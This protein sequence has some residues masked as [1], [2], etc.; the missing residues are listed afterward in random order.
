MD[1]NQ[2]L[3]DRFEEHRG[4]LRAVAYRMLGSLAEADD[5]VQDT[6]LR[7][8]GAGVGEV[9]NLRGWLT[10][11]T[12]RVCLNMLRSR[13]LR[14][15]EALSVHVP[16]PVL[17][18]GRRASA[19][20]GGAAGR[21]GR[22]RPAGGPG[23]PGPG[24]TAGVRPARHVRAAVRGDRPDGEQ[25]PGAHR[26]V[27][28]PAG[29]P[30]AP[31]PGERGSRDGRHGT[32][33]APQRHGLHDRRRPDRRDRTRSAT[34]SAS[35]RSPQASSPE[36]TWICDKRRYETTMSRRAQ[37]GIPGG[38]VFC[39]RSV[40]RARL[41]Q[42]CHANEV[43]Q[44][45]LVSSPV[46][47]RQQIGAGE[48]GHGLRSDRAGVVLKDQVVGVGR[49]EALRFESRRQ[50][51]DVTIER[52]LRLPAQGLQPRKRR[53]GRWRRLRDRVQ[54]G[55][56]RVSMV[57]RG[58]RAVLRRPRPRGDWPVGQARWRP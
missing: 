21:L 49:G 32:R 40:M 53:V 55:Q 44:H 15:E 30:V 56:V 47:C 14:R 3:A 24:R 42:V 50:D 17:E 10:T 20:G 8:S 41:E 16:D 45:L 51:G 23:H 4:H 54:A 33:T 18:R 28:R 39:G 2:W 12:A 11:V 38:V 31:S 35:A 7:L 46:D 58:H 34:R 27:A 22:P 26:V 6:W 19:R 5:A 36:A 37:G 1:E 25:R 13:N 43:V 29:G 52:H 57:R 9:V 48:N